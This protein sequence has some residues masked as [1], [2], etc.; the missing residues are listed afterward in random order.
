MVDHL[1]H[2]K[3]QCIWRAMARSELGKTDWVKLKNL[4]FETKDA[5][6][7]PQKQEK[8][9]TTK[10]FSN[11]RAVLSHVQLFCQLHVL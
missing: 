1:L 7:A 2:P 10:H 6:K 3:V 4:G 9:E 11:T 5:R 8:N